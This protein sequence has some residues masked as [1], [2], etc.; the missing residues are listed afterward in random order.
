MTIYD[1]IETNN[2]LD[3][4]FLKILNDTATAENSNKNGSLNSTKRDLQAGLLS[5]H[6]AINYMLPKHIV[7]AHK[8]GIVHIH[9][10]DYYANQMFNCCLVNLDDM[11][12][13]GTKINGKLI[14]SPTN[15]RTA[16]TVATQIVAQ[17]ASG[18]FGGQTIS[19]S[20]LAPFVRRSKGRLFDRFRSLP[21]NSGYL[22]KIVFDE[23]RKEISDSIQTVLY[24]V[25]TL[26]T[27]NGQTP[28]LS[29]ALDINEKPEY[30]EE[31]VML[32]EEL[33]SQ[34][35]QGLK[36]ED[37]VYITPTF[38]KLL[39]VLDENNAYVDSEY[40]WLTQLACECVSKRM[41]PDFLSSKILVENYGDVVYPM[42]CRSFLSPWKDENGNL[43]WW[44]RFN[45]GVTSLNLPYV[46]LLSGGN[47]DKFWQELEKYLCLC[48]DILDLR[49]EKLKGVI[50][51]ASPIHWQDGAI[52][53]LKPND[54]IDHLLK[55]GYA[56]ISLGYMGIYETVK[57]LTGE[58]HT[59]DVGC[60][61][62]NKILQ[63]MKDKCD[64]WKKET[65]YG[66]GL[67]GSPG[68]SLTDKFAKAILRDFGEIEDITDK[69]YV[70]NSYHVDIREKINAF[71]K[72][73]FEN[74]FHKISSGGAISYIEVDDMSKNPQ[75][76]ET[77][78]RFIY[79]NCQ[80]GE[81]NCKFDYCYKCK[82]EGQLKINENNQFECP[83]CGNID[84]KYLYHVRR[85]CGYLGCN[86]FNEGR[87]ND[88]KN[89]ITH[90]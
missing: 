3:D 68:E 31:T 23:L 63:Y 64:L 75:A 11:L 72:L 38:P 39:Y 66:F 81:I 6:F 40:Y 89:R 60:E 1:K 57:Y 24:Q 46:A 12:Q 55:D 48:K 78:V 36:N 19:I 90:L 82:F 15:L 77:L 28:F 88:I 2:N 42:G 8:K 33:L 87:M 18:Q 67:Y 52:A 17:I 61:L 41:M 13:N 30:V 37:G 65:G 7:E 32:V 76:I 27:S 9:D 16:C 50:S 62:S 35:K 4:E 69:G 25:N 70:T 59:T 45:M 43:K 29:I 83:C 49:I 58:S 73:K 5:K 47:I 22:S 26:Q 84:S 74:Q 79:E 53:R 10:L 51:D 14:E 80:Y 56:T 86:Q 54:T 21:L 20:H 71:D 44:G 34:F 85:T